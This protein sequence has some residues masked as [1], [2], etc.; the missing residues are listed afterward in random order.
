MKF[1]RRALS[2]LV[3][4][5][6]AT[7]LITPPASAH[8]SWAT[9][10][11]EAWGYTDVREP[12]RA[13]TGEDAPVGAWRDAD[14]KHH[15]S[16]AYYTFDLSPFRH[17][18]VFTAAAW[19]PETA[20]TD[21]ARTRATELWRT[22][23]AP[24]PTWEGQPA[25]LA[26]QPGP[27]APSGC[28]WSRVTWDVTETIR[29]AITAGQPRVTFA[30]RIA[31][32]R[33]GDVA[34][35]RRYDDLR[36]TFE[37]NNPPGTPTD[38]AV[39]GAPCG[40]EPVFM[41]YTQTVLRAQVTDP[42]GGYG[43]H[44]RFTV[45]DTSTPD[46][47]HEIASSPTGSTDVSTYVPESLL[48]D[49]RTLEWTVRGHDGE[50]A[51]PVSASCRLTLDHTR[52]HTPPTVS[53]TDYPENGG[54]PGTGGGAV[55][56]RFTFDANGVED[57]VGFHYD[58]G[59]V[60]ADR[61][62]GSATV[63]F[64]PR[65]E[66]NSRIDVV[67]VDRAGNRSA[68]RAYFFFV[69]VTAPEVVWAPTRPVVGVP[70][71]VTF[72]P[73]R[74]GDRLVE[75]SYQ[76]NGGPQTTVAADA[77]GEVKVVLVPDRVYPNRLEVVGTTESGTRT[78]A[79]QQTFHAN[80]G[81]PTV[82]GDVYTEWAASGGVGVPGTFTFTPAMPGV[83]EYTYYFYSDDEV[84]VLPAAA[85]GTASFTFTP[86]EAGW[87]ELFVRSRT[88]SGLVSTERTFVFGVAG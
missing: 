75:Y 47:R 24:R 48:V 16:K 53:S 68:S 65:S 55:P 49:G 32:D 52:P 88:A 45:W 51:S 17:A 37:Y 5:C 63:E 77:A 44:G 79:T 2:T 23:V 82:T 1:V 7:A 31:E 84:T 9:P 69:R 3:V 42:D 36:I 8:R 60:A 33:Q 29:Q 70:T 64:T 72:T 18:T 38:L 59:Y 30:L 56:G 85:D 15:L 27:H 74:G 11:A 67:S 19:A 81:E 66:G 43:V 22:E 50:T 71:E 10:G 61:P 73:A 57:V 26:K 41:H 12:A 76:F 25:E 87:N 39:S 13:F 35:G 83:V 62:G 6:A 46:Q 34:Y 54:A 14:G 58:G 21:C 86:T 20:V 4:A 78:A 40:D 28:T 80:G